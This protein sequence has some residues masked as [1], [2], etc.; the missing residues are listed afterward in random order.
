[1][2]THLFSESDKLRIIELRGAGESYAQIGESVGCS[3]SGAKYVFDKYKDE[4]TI[5]N[6]GIFSV[7]L[8]VT[9]TEVRNICSS[10]Y[11]IIPI[12]T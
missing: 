1:M 5:Q 7:D 6:I 12:P 8:K 11:G 2:S 4:G 9:Q 10:T 3:K